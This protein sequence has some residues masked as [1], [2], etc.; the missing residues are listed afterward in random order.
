MVEMVESNLNTIPETEPGY[1]QLFA[2][3]I[4]R[5]YWLL[6]VL[7]IAL[8][9]A[10]VKAVR[11]KP[12]YQSSL[13]L[14][15]EP[16]IKGSTQEGQAGAEKEIVDPKLEV[17]SATQLSLMQSTQLLQSAVTLLRPDYPDLNA[18]QI[19]QSL[20]VTQVEGEEK[21]KT[22]L[23]AAT[24]TD[25]DP[26]KT[27][28]VLEAMQRVY[29]DYNR[30][31]Q[32]LR[33]AKGLEFIDKELPKVGESVIQA[34]TALKQFRTNHK[35]IEP[36]VQAKDL[37]DAVNNIEQ[38][39]RTNQSLYQEY[40][41]R[42]NA[43]QQQVANSPQNAL[44]SSRLSQSSRYQGLL[45][46]IQKTEL[47]LAK[48]RMRFN[49]EN[50]VIQKLLFQRQEQLT[51]L[52]QEGQR[53]VGGNSAQLNGT[54][55]RLLTEGQLGQT[56]LTLVGQLLDMQK[57]LIGVKARE[58][59]L[60]Q[61]EQQLRSRLERFPGLLAEYNR[62]QS[63]IKLK[64]DTLDQ[65]EKARQDLSLKIARGGFDWKVIEAPLPGEKT[66][67]K[68]QQTILLGAVVG[69]ILGGLAAFL[70]EMTDDSVRSSDDLKKQVAFP[71][72]G[73]TPELPK[74][75]KSEPSLHLPF[76][77]PQ[78]LAPATSEPI[79]KLP[80]GKPQVFAPW[81]IEVIH[82]PPSGESLDLIYKNIQLLNSVSTLSSLMVTSAM[83]GEGKST[84]ALGLA[85]SAARLHQ[86]VLLIDADLRQPTLHQK[87]N[88]PNEYGLSTLLS[89][90]ATLPIQSSIHAS[91]SYIDILTS[92]P[93]P[94]DPVNL[95]SS[96]RMGELMAGFEKSYDLVLLDAPPVLGMVD[97]LITAS[98]CRGVVLVARI[99]KV[100]KSELTQTTG[101]LS[102]LN[103]IGVV[104][105]G[106]GSATKTYVS[107][108]VV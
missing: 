96:P 92:G 107:N 105:N 81:T 27:K 16:I 17:D 49:D 100:T 84:L 7:C 64:R 101:M 36:E 4:R 68:Q 98:F 79:I 72:L 38:E 50:P 42:Y 76:S 56:D 89:G 41:A 83:A 12:T 19:K 15:V 34:E 78:V 1:G 21:A 40:Q 102:K 57:N 77:K 73:M 35:L 10:T 43:L 67:P 66:G 61:K 58:E 47:A 39:R 82:W 85:I 65:L 74:T 9:I 32:R 80:F 30:E 88:L 55:E 26:I 75:K 62:L 69:L 53:S 14:L 44:V 93:M 70:R 95:L 91:S 33:L 8:G 52:Q 18:K 28:K 5:R 90:D 22:K 99:G 46:E 108:S 94:T 104:A 23:F 48:E 11:A 103:I 106:V 6:G 54:G 71:L 86:R 20:T 31:E 87:L 25:N 97:A 13:Q 24:Y 51:L 60:A 59:T 29:Q 2:I 37:T 3:L 45:N 63:D